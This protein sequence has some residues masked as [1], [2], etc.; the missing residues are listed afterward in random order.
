[1]NLA[2]TIRLYH[3]S[4]EILRK[5]EFG[6]GSLHRD[7]GPGFYCTEYPDLAAEWA[8]RDGADGYANCYRLDPGGLEVLELDLRPGNLLRW[9]AL[10]LRYRSITTRDRLCDEAAAL[11]LDRYDV[12]PGDYDLILGPRADDSALS[13]AQAF[14]DNA[15]PLGLLG[16]SLALDPFGQQVVLTSRKA[17]A[18]L[19][20]VSQEAAAWTRYDPIRRGRDALLR[21]RWCAKLE[22]KGAAEGDIYLTDLLKGAVPDDD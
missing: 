16:D 20:F 12:E 2:D 6:A 22:H 10:L 3:G 14:L 5:P 13:F 15:L 11:I 1:M 8:C 17:L 7:F 18:R 9:L 21:S 4:K 19:E